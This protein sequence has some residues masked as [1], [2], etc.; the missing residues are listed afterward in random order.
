MSHNGNF[1][2]SEVVS[3]PVNICQYF[4]ESQLIDN[5]FGN[6]IRICTDEVKVFEEFFGVAVF[7][8]IFGSCKS[9]ARNNVPEAEYLKM[10]LGMS[11]SPEKVG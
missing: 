10:A 4:I 3:C 8:Q 9:N 5:I 6:M 11:K 7:I 2:Y 1:I